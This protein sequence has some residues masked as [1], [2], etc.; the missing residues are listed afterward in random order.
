MCICVCAHR[1]CLFL[2]LLWAFQPH[3]V[4]T[5]HLL[6][7]HSFTDDPL[8]P[9][10]TLGWTSF[11]LLDFFPLW[12]AEMLKSWSQS[13]IT[14]K[15]EQMCRWQSGKKG[16]ERFKGMSGEF[17]RCSL[18]LISKL[19]QNREEHQRKRK[20]NRKSDKWKQRSAKC[21]VYGAIHVTGLP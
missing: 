4:N 20:K 21:H 13:Q 14:D 7:Q 17:R 18:I 6:K 3:I 19:T 1:P 12:A 8:W 10:S 16:A 9:I 5:T 11:L 2:L 15:K